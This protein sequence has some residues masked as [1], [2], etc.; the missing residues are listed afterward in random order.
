MLIITMILINTISIVGFV[1]HLDNKKEE[2]VVNSIEEC[3]IS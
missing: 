2:K 3:R 1:A